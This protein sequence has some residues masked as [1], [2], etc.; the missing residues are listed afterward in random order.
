[1]WKKGLSL[2]FKNQL[3]FL[4]RSF[5]SPVQLMFRLHTNPTS[6]AVDS[7][8]FAKIIIDT[9]FQH[10]PFDDND[11]HLVRGPFSGDRTRGIPYFSI[12]L[13]EIRSSVYDEETEEFFARPHKD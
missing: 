11:L 9:L 4:N 6:G 2:K 13:R 1:M 7:G 12:V 5:V 8:N 10:L 3:Q